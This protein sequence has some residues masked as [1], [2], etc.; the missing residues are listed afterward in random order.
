MRTL[1]PS[2]VPPA[3]LKPSLAPSLNMPLSVAWSLLLSSQSKPPALL[4]SSSSK[5]LQP[6]SP[7][8]QADLKRTN[9]LL[10]LNLNN[11]RL[12]NSTPKA[13]QDILNLLLAAPH[14]AH[15]SGRLHS[16][17]DRCK[18]NFPS[19]HAALPEQHLPTLSF[20]PQSPNSLCSICSS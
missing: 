10:F 16:T 17:L 9:T 8:S 19:H 1:Q 20:L 18:T 14:I 5:Q 15:L 13:K 6:S 3:P 7:A 12:L 11:L 4:D 2:P